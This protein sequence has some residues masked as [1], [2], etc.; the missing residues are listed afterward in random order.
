MKKTLMNSAVRAPIVPA[1]T[2]GAFEELS[3]RTSE[4]GALITI[5]RDPSL[6]YRVHVGF[7]LGVTPV[8]DFDNGVQT[9]GAVALREVADLFIAL[10]DELDDEED[11]DWDFGE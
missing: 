10:A 1:P 5:T 4:S 9:L 2:Q 11:N 7:G 3:T 8:R 6:D